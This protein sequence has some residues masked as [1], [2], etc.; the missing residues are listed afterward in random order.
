[1]WYDAKGHAAEPHSDRETLMMTS[2]FKQVA[3]RNQLVRIRFE[4]SWKLGVSVPPQKLFD[5]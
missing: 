5:Y 4:D 3:C 2:Y 1:M